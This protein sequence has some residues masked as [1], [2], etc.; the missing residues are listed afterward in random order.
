MDRRRRRKDGLGAVTP[1]LP[2]PERGSV[3]TGSA[4]FLGKDEH[5]AGINTVWIA[6]LVMVRVVDDRISRAIPIGGAAD[7]PQAVA[8]RDDGSR[9]LR[10]RH[11]GG[12]AGGGPARSSRRPPLPPSPRPRPARARAREP[13]TP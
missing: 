9:D 11:S 5:L 8:A 4:R 3:G 12:R 1:S 2:S 6:D 10:G 7:A 13:L